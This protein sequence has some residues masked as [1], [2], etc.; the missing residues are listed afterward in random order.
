MKKP[1]TIMGP[2]CGYYKRHK[3]TQWLL[4]KLYVGIAIDVKNPTKTMNPYANIATND[5]CQQLWVAHM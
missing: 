2:I 3:K 4:W 5:K 1:A